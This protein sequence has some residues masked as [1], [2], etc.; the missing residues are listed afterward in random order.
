MKVGRSS[1]EAIDGE[2]LHHLVLVVRDLRLE[3]VAH[4]GDE[5]A[6]GL[7]ALGR[8]Q[9]LVVGVGEVELDLAREEL[10]VVELDAVVDDLVHRVARGG[11][12]AADAR[13][14]RGGATRCG[15][16]SARPAS[17]RRGPRA[18]RSR[19]SA[20]SIRSR[21]RSAISSTRRKAYMPT[22]SVGLAGVLRGPRVERLLVRRGLRD[23]HE[24]LGRE[25]EVDLLVVDAVLVGH[26]DGDEED[27]DDVGAVRVDP[28]PRL[29]VV[30]ERREQH[31]ERGRVDVR[32]GG[33]PRSSSAVRVDQVDPA[34]GD[35]HSPRLAAPS[36]AQPGLAST[37]AAGARRRGLGLG[38]RRGERRARVALELGEVALGVEGAHTAR[39]GGRDRLAVD[40]ILHVADREHAGDVRLGRAGLRE[41]VAVLVVVELVDEELRV[42]VVADRDEEALRLDARASRRSRCCAAARR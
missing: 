2:P 30:H 21:Y 34:L 26:R 12:R 16:G 13:A 17:P 40:V 24:L 22:G 18:R 15:R 19:R 9:E 14:G 20:S 41:Q 38:P 11:E 42:R 5:V 6:R 27:A 28:R 1:S 29:V 37:A 10:A 25:D 36:A 31:R 23:R 8:A 3:V 39:A 32:P 4:A 35:G 7:E 33:A